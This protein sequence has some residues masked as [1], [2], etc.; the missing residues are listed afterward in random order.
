[1]VNED[2][3]A[4]SISPYAEFTVG[5]VFFWAGVDFGGLG[6]GDV[7]ASPFIGTAYHF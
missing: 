3:T 2:F 1:V 4:L 6:S 7:S 5:R